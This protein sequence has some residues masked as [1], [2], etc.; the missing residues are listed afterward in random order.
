MKP[1]IPGAAGRGQVK[2]DVKNS[3]SRETWK[4]QFNA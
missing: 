2:G 3:D 1:G 4:V